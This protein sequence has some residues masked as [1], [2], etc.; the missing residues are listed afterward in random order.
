[1]GVPTTTPRL[2]DST[3]ST[4]PHTPQVLLIGCCSPLLNCHSYFCFFF[5]RHSSCSF[6]IILDEAHKIKSRTNNTAKSVLALR[7]RYKW[8]MSGTPLQ[9]RISELYSLVRLLSLLKLNMIAFAEFGLTD[10]CLFF[11]SFVL[12]SFTGPVFKNDTVFVLLLQT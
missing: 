2:H 12:F 1:M 11:C 10:A 8:C 3:Y 6:R 9:N 5:L 7:G 4:T